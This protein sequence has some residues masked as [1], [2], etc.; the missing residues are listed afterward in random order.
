MEYLTQRR[1]DFVAANFFA[2]LEL[3]DTD[4]LFEIV[5][6]LVSLTNTILGGGT[7]CCSRRNRLYHRDELKDGERIAP[8]VKP[9]VGHLNESH[10]F[11]PAS[12]LIKG[13]KIHCFPTQES[14]RISVLNFAS[15]CWTL[16]NNFQ[17][18]DQSKC[19]RHLFAVFT[20]F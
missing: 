14:V 20:W 10:K 7:V 5:Y 18:S 17:R 16:K 11:V 8:W 4:I 15:N 12:P 1:K 19:K 3:E 2:H 6:A 13:W 9:S